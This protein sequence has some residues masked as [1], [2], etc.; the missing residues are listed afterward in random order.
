MK[1]LDKIGMVLFS[2]IILILAMLYCFILSGLVGVDIF[3]RT[4]LK[5]VEYEVIGK[6][7]YGIAILLIILALKCIFFNSALSGGKQ[8]KDNGILLENEN[9]KLLVSKETIESLT[10][11][12]VKTFESAENAITKVDID[13]EK[14]IKIY[15]TLFVYPDAVIKD[16][17]VA[18]QTNVKNTIKKSIDLDVKEVNVRIK[19]ISVKK[20]LNA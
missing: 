18:L 4:I 10:N 14:N 17:T 13:E 6:I 8:G 7:S 1:I 11:S 2:V 15:I 3:E 16:L 19:N 5:V 9:G 12:V 20:E